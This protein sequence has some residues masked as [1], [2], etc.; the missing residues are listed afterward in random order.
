MKELQVK[1]RVSGVN[2][3]DTGKYTSFVTFLPDQSVGTMS[4]LILRDVNL[5]LDLPVM[6]TIQF[7]PVRMD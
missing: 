5:P 7:P 1:G 3:D 6:V 4:P 2:K